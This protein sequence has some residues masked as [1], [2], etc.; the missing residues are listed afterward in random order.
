[1]F[2][3]EELMSGSGR[4]PKSAAIALMLAF[5]T[6][7]FAACGGGTP[8]VALPAPQQ[9][10]APGYDSPSAAVAG[11][12]TGYDNSDSQQICAYVAPLQH[13]YCDFLFGNALRSSVTGWQLG[14]SLVRGDKAIVVVTADKWCIAKVC[15]GNRD[16]KK[17]LPN[18]NRGFENAFDKT[19]NWLPA[20]SVVELKGKWYVALA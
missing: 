4:I 12:V 19:T 2:T 3:R 5:V 17:G 15:V 16:P 10:V 7:A 13:E 6:V 8:T 14:N 1:M 11:Y 18:K 20:V 9:T